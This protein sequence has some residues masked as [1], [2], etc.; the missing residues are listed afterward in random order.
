MRFHRTASV[1]RCV[2]CIP[3]VVRSEIRLH[4]ARFGARQDRSAG[5]PSGLAIINA[6]TAKPYRWISFGEQTQVNSRKRRRFPLCEQ[7]SCCLLTISPAPFG[8]NRRHCPGKCALWKDSLHDE[9]STVDRPIRSAN[10]SAV[11]S[12]SCPARIGQPR[13]AL[14]QQMCFPE[15]RSLSITLVRGG[16]AIVANPPRILVPV[17]VPV[18][19]WILFTSVQRHAISG[20][21]VCAVYK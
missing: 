1:G 9:A 14:I 21:R 2:P 7:H 8:V 17:L 13:P 20:H 10:R 11:H 5:S 18:R 16:L 12:F 4:L 15:S 6:L 3:H 19:T